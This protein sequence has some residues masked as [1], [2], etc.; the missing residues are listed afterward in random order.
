MNAP[1][2]SG[3]L[4]PHD[5]VD[6]RLGIVRAV[7][8]VPLH[9]MLPHSLHLVAAVLSGPAAHHAAPGGAAWWDPA[10]AA[11]AALGEAA[12]RYCVGSAP[13]A[14]WH[15]SWTELAADGVT[16]IDPADLALHSAAQHAAPGFPFAR[17]DR[18]LPVAWV[19]GTE[20]G[21]APV[22]VPRSLL[23]LDLPE[24]DSP[25]HLPVNAG[26]AAGPDW[27]TAVCSALEE[28]LERHCVATAWLGGVA[29]ERLPTPGWLSGVL[30][31]PTAAVEATVLGVPNEFGLPV[32]AVLL[33][34]RESGVLGMG[35]ALR[36]RLYAAVRKAAAE[37][38]VSCQAAHQLD[39]GAALA[40][41]LGDPA[42]TALRPWRAD[43]GY[44]QQYRPDWRDVVDVF[45]HVQ[46]YLDPALWP[47][48]DQRLSTGVRSPG[49]PARWELSDRAG[50]VPR[51]RAAGLRVVTVDLTTPDVAACGLVVVRVVV[52]GLRATAP[53]AFPFLGGSWA[54]P[55]TCTLPFPHA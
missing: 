50:Y 6:E 26:L 4:S 40:A 55:P 42:T 41:W 17:F 2:A 28:L 33:R 37:A 31:G 7:E 36:P 32:A 19:P 16:A 5:L 54:T 52:P 14:L 24:A 10:A 47:V 13:V 49:W 21:G 20:L 34:D 43:R 1:T 18:E 11:A 53:A 51:V 15:T 29:F 12:E 22:L 3:A 44:A 45:C 38:V 30:G 27:N 25:T 8:P 9:P 35:T 39:D 23:V 46:L 48:L